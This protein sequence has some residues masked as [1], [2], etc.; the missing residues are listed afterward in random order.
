MIP[1]LFCRLRCPLGSLCVIDLLH[2][3][4]CATPTVLCDTHSSILEDHDVNFNSIPC[5]PV[6]VGSLMI[7]QVSGS[8]SSLHDSHSVFPPE[9]SIGVPVYSF[10]SL[11]LMDM[12]SPQSSILKDNMSP[13]TTTVHA[14]VLYPRSSITPVLHSDILTPAILYAPTPSLEDPASW[15]T[16]IFVRKDESSYAPDKELDKAIYEPSQSYFKGL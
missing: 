5:S 13:G 6:S 3:D 11:S 16:D 7:P 4:E 8:P 1:I 9:V 12:L 15:D 14:P 2:S 10:A